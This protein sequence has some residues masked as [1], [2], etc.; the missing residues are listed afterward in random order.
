VPISFSQAALGGEIEVPTLDGRVKLKIPAETQTDRMFR[1]RNKGVKSVRSQSTGDLMCKVIIE[2]PI[3]LSAKQRELL[4]EFER[5][6][7]HKK[8][9][10]KS[11]GFLNNIKTFFEDIGK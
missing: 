1:M 2:T 3:K 7:D 10:P 6:C 9:K 11:D 4:K 8:H 5:S